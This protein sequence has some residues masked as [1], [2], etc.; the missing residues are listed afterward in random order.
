LTWNSRP[1]CGGTGVQF[2][3]ER[4][5]NLR[6]IRNPYKGLVDMWQ[7]YDNASAPPALIAEGGNS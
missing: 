7:L 2:A 6:G 5:S 1:V 4:L 3:L